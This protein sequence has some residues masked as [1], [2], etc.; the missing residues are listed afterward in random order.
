VLLHDIAK[1]QTFAQKER[2][3]YDHHA[4]MSGEMASCI[5]KR[6]KFPR[7]F[8]ERVVFGIEHHFMMKQLI[9]MPTGRQR[10]WFLKPEFPILMTVFE[11]DI[12]GTTPSDYEMFNK[13]KSIYDEFRAQVRVEPRKLLS[14]EEVMEILGVEPGPRHVHEKRPHHSRHRRP[15][16]RKLV[17]MA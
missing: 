12:A 15:P 1:P 10:S 2:I 5:L 11:A 17:P 14:G 3:R 6:L 9:E 13:L 16:G 4:E 7:K 8:I